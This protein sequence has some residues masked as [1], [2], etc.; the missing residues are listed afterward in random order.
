LFALVLF[1]LTISVIIVPPKLILNSQEYSYSK[2]ASA[3]TGSD[4]QSPC[5]EQ[6]TEKDDELQD[7]FLLFCFVSEPIFALPANEHDAFCDKGLVP[8]E[9]ISNFPLYLAIQ[10]LLI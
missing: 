3:P 4:N 2:Q 9:A 5:E 7:G 8:V 10:V 1:S 6:E